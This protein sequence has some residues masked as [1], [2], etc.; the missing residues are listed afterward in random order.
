MDLVIQV[1]DQAEV[2]GL[3]GAQGFSFELDAGGVDGQTSLLVGRGNRPV[4]DGRLGEVLAQVAVHI[5]G[6]RA[7]RWVR[8]VGGDGEEEWAGPIAVFQELQRLVDDVMGRVQGFVQVPGA[9][10][11]AVE[12]EA[13]ATDAVDLVGAGSQIVVIRVDFVSGGELHVVVPVAGGGGRLMHCAADHIGVVAGSTQLAGQGRA[14]DR[15]AADEAGHGVGGRKLAGEQGA[16]PARASILGVSRQGWPSTPRQSP[17]CWSVMM[18]MKLGRVSMR[19]S[20]LYEN[21]SV[22]GR[23]DLPKKL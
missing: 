8:S 5:E 14:G 6:R 23:V 21:Y 10:V 1:V 7:E 11:P 13:V 22:I 4:A 9:S 20:L 18:R 12:V 3:A 16:V 19:F 15:H 2:A 17:R